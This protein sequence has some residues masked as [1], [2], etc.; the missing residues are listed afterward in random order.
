MQIVT[1]E[2]IFEY[3]H[4]CGSWTVV[5]EESRYPGMCVLSTTDEEHVIDVPLLLTRSQVEMTVDK[6]SMIRAGSVSSFEVFSGCVS[7]AA[8]LSIKYGR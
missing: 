2:T 6:L 5:M 1:T 3:A 8:S 4:P 7:G